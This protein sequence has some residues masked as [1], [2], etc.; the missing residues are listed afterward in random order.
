MAVGLHN[1]VLLTALKHFVW[2]AFPPSLA[3]LPSFPTAVLMELI[4]SSVVYQ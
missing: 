1:A 4:Q 2:P 3:I